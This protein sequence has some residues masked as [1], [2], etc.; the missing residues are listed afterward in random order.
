MI[1]TNIEIKKSNRVFYI[2]DNWLEVKLKHLIN[3]EVWKGD[4]TDPVGL[5]A[6]FMD[7]D[8]EIIANSRRE[9]W[10]ELLTVLSFVFEPPKWDTLKMADTIDLDNKI[11]KVPKK[12]ELE[13][14]GQ[15]V[16]AAQYMEG[17]KEDS[18][19]IKLIP[20]VMAVYLQPLID[21]KFSRTRL[22]Y[23]KRIILEM[24]A[25]KAVPIGRF[26]FLKLLKSRNYGMLGLK[27]FQAI[28]KKVL[29]TSKRD[30]KNWNLSATY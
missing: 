3:L 28:I 26:F 2:P 14:F 9:Y 16:L 5:L 24:P 12:L 11:I 21:G 1:K 19:N 10:T 17:I 4:E 6:C 7:I 27:P 30:L 23:T 25:I 18:E 15:M 29:F 8:P 13:R 22:D 20:D